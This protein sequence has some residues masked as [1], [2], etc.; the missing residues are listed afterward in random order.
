MNGNKELEVGLIHE[1]IWGGKTIEYGS[2]P[3]TF[4]DYLRIVFARPAGKSGFKGEKVNTL[5]NHLGV[6][7]IS[8]TKKYVDKIPED[9]DESIDLD[10]FKPDSKA[11]GGK[12]VS[13]YYKGGKT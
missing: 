12:I 8:L 4:S 2:Q 11:K 6:W 13:S 1:A 9:E 3:Q 7:D 5:G 10:L